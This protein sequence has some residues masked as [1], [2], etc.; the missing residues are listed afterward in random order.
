MIWSPQ[1]GNGRAMTQRDSTVNFIPLTEPNSSILVEFPPTKPIVS[2]FAAHRTGSKRTERQN[3]LANT[4]SKLLDFLLGIILVSAFP[5]SWVKPKP[6]K[7]NVCLPG[8]LFALEIV[9]SVKSNYP[10][11]AS[12]R[13]SQVSTGVWKWPNSSPKRRARGAERECTW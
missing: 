3:L 5:L 2:Y 8:H 11:R 12:A 4:L 9:L 10:V 1:L 7:L 13:T 6:T